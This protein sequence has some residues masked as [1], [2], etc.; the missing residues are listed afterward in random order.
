MLRFECVQRTKILVVAIALLGVIHARDAHAQ[1]STPEAAPEAQ[2][3][4]EPHP[5]EWL[6]PLPGSVDPPRS[7]PRP[8]GA[9]ENPEH[10]RTLLLGAGLGACFV[11]GR[12]SS[13]GLCA[14][15]DFSYLIAFR[16]GAV[17]FGVELSYERYSNV[18]EPGLVPGSDVLA[19]MSG[20]SAGIPIG[21]RFFEPNAAFIPY[22]GI[23]TLIVTQS[24]RYVVPGNAVVDTSTERIG[25]RPFF[26]AEF[27][28][29]P[30]AIYTEVSYRETFAL[31]PSAPQIK[32]SGS[33]LTAGY[34][35]RF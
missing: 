20:L 34:R 28:L 27:R 9:L 25:V 5:D 24:S 8:R 13:V 14:K 23:T 2:P 3:K 35:L 4:P 19:D 17:T 30:G 29:G 26:G 1:A 16:G 15:V 31:F 7:R 11:G 22:L 32:H 12:W 21:V 10:E 33:Q 18:F 6:A